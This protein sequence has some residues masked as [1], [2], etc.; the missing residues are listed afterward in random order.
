[1]AMKGRKK[2]LASD[3]AEDRQGRLCPLGKMWTCGEE[4]GCMGVCVLDER[5]R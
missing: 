1:M 5:G 2:C 3:S 4:G